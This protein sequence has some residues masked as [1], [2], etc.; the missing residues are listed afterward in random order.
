VTASGRPFTATLHVGPVGLEAEGLQRGRSPFH[1]GVQFHGRTCPQKSAIHPRAGSSRENS[2]GPAVPITASRPP[3]ADRRDLQHA[4]VP[5]IFDAGA[6]SKMFM[7]RADLRGGSRQW[8]PPSP[9][10][11]CV[12]GD[13]GAAP[14]LRRN[15]GRAQGSP[16]GARAGSLRHD[17]CHLL[18]GNSTQP[19]GGG[20]QPIL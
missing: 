4:C 12:S 19:S 6:S 9:A 2:S 16:Y 10:G 3:E 8:R 20:G 18:A 13:R 1:Q 11:T 17:D 5:G 15:R 14:E 7:C